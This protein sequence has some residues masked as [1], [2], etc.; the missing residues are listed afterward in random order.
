MT[1]ESLPGN[2]DHIFRFSAVG[3]QMFF[4]KRR[5]GTKH[6]VICRTTFSMITVASL[7]SVEVAY[8]ANNVATGCNLHSFN[9][10]APDPLVDAAAKA[11][12]GADPAI[13]Y[14]TDVG[15]TVLGSSS[16]TAGTGLSGTDA[17]TSFVTELIA[18][19]RVQEAQVCQAGFE[20][21]GG[22]C[23]SSRNKVASEKPSRT[24]P[25]SVSSGTGK[26]SS[27]LTSR[28]R[29]PDGAEFKPEA[30]AQPVNAIWSEAFYDFEKRSG[31]GTALAPASRTQQTS[32]M[33]FG[34]DRTFRVGDTQLILGVLGSMSRTKQSFSPTTSNVSQDTTFTVDLS[35]LDN[36]T[37]LSTIVE[38]QVNVV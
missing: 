8:A 4:T 30:V 1:L 13:K 11:K 9:N 31:L 10:P 5:V 16:G 32:G 7:L 27:A 18:Q 17:S 14:L 35:Q 29:R 38:R 3:R 33:L 22:V 12:F 26:P 24:K 15:N 37:D 20:K 34:G 28:D 23:Q 25:S 2:I 36:N 21:V 19:R 6:S